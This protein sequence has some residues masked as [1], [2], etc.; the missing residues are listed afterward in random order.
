L[1]NTPI[2]RAAWAFYVVLVF[3]ILFVISLGA[4]FFYSAQG[5]L[6]RFLNGARATAWLTQFFLPHIT[7]TGN[8]VFD[9]TTCGRRGS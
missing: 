3:E 7:A 9:H 5:Q 4:L 2:L 6:L 1:R 8:A